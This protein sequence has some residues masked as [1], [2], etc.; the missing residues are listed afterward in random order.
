[1]ACVK[2][3][4]Q[5]ADEGLYECGRYRPHFTHPTKP[6]TSRIIVRIADS[7]SPVCRVTLR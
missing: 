4:G 3:G 7:H 5:N 2:A 1:M 6:F